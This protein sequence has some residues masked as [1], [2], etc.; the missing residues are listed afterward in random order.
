MR[1]SATVK[2][3]QTERDQLRQTLMAGCSE[4]QALQQQVAELRAKLQ[5]AQGPTAAVTAAADTAPQ[6]ATA[7]A[8]GG[9]G[10][11]RVKGCSKKV[12]APADQA[13]ISRAYWGSLS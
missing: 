10:N 3:F 7:T 1:L 6:A 8:A 9:S 5:E 2:S 12:D 11:G 13:N 4:R